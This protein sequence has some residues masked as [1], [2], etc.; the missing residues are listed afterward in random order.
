MAELGVGDWPVVVGLYG[1][2]TPQPWLVDNKLEHDGYQLFS[3]LAAAFSWSWSIQNTPGHD[4]VLWGMNDADVPPRSESGR[5]C[6]FQV[7]LRQIGTLPLIPLATCSWRTLARLGDTSVD[8]V[9]MYLPIQNAGSGRPGL[10]SS[11]AWFAAANPADSVTVDVSY[12]LGE[13]Q[14]PEDIEDEILKVTDWATGPFALLAAAHASRRPQL[15]PE[16]PVSVWMGPTREP[17]MLAAQLPEW[18]PE[19]IGWLVGLLA[20]GLHTAGVDSPAL[21]SIRR[22]PQ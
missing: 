1:H 16:I 17:R 2:K 12:D 18:T 19:A 9:Q 6:W 11:L 22:R 13:F 15:R 14:L 5:L 7:S 20:D 3:S 8:G 4:G 10:L 21:I